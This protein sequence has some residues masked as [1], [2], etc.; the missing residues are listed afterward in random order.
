MGEKL[1]ELV[2]FQYM[3]QATIFASI[4]EE[5]GIVNFVTQSNALEPAMG[6]VVY[7]NDVIKEQAEQLLKAFDESNSELPE[8]FDIDEN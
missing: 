5:E 4:L 3:W 8:D 6:Y 7:V 2:H 1:I